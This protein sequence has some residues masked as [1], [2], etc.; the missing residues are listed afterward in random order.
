MIQ[1]V[2][3]MMETPASASDGAIRRPR[4]IIIGCDGTNNTLT[5][6]SHDTNVLKM[7][8]QLAPENE[9]RI[10]YYDPGVGSPDQLPPLGLLN[11]L[12][13]KGERLAGLANGRGIYE[14]IQEA[15]LFLVD[16]YQPGDEIYIFGFSRG[17]FTARS[18]A[19]MVKLFGIIG[20][21]SKSLILTLIRVYF[22]T[23]SNSQ[24]DIGGW[25]GF[26]AGLTSSRYRRNAIVADETKI[27]SPDTTEK[28]IRL[29]LSKTKERRSTREEVATQVRNNFASIDGVSASVHF[30]GV[31]DTVESVGIPCLSRSITSAAK[32][33]NEHG[34]RHIRHALSMDE[35]RVTFAPRLYWDK[36]YDDHPADPARHQS[37]RQ[38]WFR[39]VHSDIGG[40]Y[41]TKEAGLSDQ[42]YRW[43]LN[44]AIACGLNTQPKR[45]QSEHAAKPFIAHDPCHQTPRWGVAGLTV[46]SNITHRENGVDCRLPV[47]TEGVASV[48]DPR[49]HS[50]WDADLR[51]AH[52][53]TWLAFLCVI[54][55]FC[56][57][58]SLAWSA[59]VGGVGEPRFWSRIW[60]GTLALEQ[61]KSTYFLS[62]DSNRLPFVPALAAVAPAVGATLV[63][64]GLIAAYSWLLGLYST[65]AFHIMVGHRDPQGTIPLLFK[66]GYAPMCVVIADIVENC[67]TLMTL[68]CINR[69]MLQTSFLIG[70]FMAVATLLK[71][72]GVMGSIA[73][74]G[75]GIGMKVWKST[76]QLVGRRAR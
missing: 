61:W 15:Y 60:T 62:I 39:G 23:P 52:W 30:I 53:Q 35:H 65:W 18:V 43:M 74:V 68:W 48:P 49:I 27:T 9:S 46:R 5:G 29:Y 37:L 64:V 47:A 54:V 20:P 16:T 70:A 28:N 31:W 38:R 55:L 2:E 6:G 19:G 1:T 12:R 57:Y 10:L 25:Q 32:T 73:L 44:E 24:A 26:I 14:N 56:W 21:D 67:F 50:V 11:D 45:H 63:D 66:L 13:R 17:A 41:D 40:G 36:D 71:W 34:L 4:Q 42:A 69:G 58:G 72:L 75:S 3:A 8:S 33:R 7:I 59:A 76:T 22:S 51:M